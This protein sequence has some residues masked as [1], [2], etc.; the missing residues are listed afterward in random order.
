MADDPVVDDDFFLVSFPPQ[1]HGIGPLGCG[2][3]TT[4]QTSLFSD[5]GFPPRRLSQRLRSARSGVGDTQT[6]LHRIRNAVPHLAH[7]P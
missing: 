6:P 1:V 2:H 3:M 7:L 5:L 4:L